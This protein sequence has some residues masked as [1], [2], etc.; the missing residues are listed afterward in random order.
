MDGN[1]YNNLNHH[2]QGGKGAGTTFMDGTR[3]MIDEDIDEHIGLASRPW[4]DHS[5]L[6]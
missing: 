4:E 6:Y 5:R 3:N 2:G 1:D